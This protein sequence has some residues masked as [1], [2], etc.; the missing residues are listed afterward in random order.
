MKGTPVSPTSFFDAPARRLPRRAI[1]PTASGGFTMLEVMI[2]CAIVAILAAIALP[3]YSDYVKR[4]KIIEATSALSD[5]RVRFEQSYLDNKTYA[6]ACAAVQTAAGQALKAFTL[7]CCTTA[8]TGSTYSC[9]A[10]GKATE[11]MSGFSYKIEQTN[12]T[13]NVK[14]STITASGWNGNGS[15]WAVRRDGTCS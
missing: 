3:N 15:C 4:G 12:A 10:T 8:P 6:G 9:T 5:A 11:G 1:N 2:V 14:S 7:D 13:T